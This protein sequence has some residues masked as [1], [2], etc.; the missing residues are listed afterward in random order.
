MSL[1]LVIRKVF[2]TEMA[3][4][5]GW[6]MSDN[7][8]QGYICN[9][10]SYWS[11]QEGWKRERGFPTEEK[12]EHKDANVSRRQH[13]QTGCHT[14]TAKAVQPRTH[15]KC[16]YTLEEALGIRGRH[17]QWLQRDE[18]YK[19]VTLSHLQRYSA[20]VSDAAGMAGLSGIEKRWWSMPRVAQKHGTDYLGKVRLRVRVRVRELLW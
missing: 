2:R 1:V 18:D 10:T 16:L 12:R 7:V 9:Q 6:G 20:E 19:M 13:D 3:T 8:M 14:S 5:K 15:L 11:F 4:E 17:Q